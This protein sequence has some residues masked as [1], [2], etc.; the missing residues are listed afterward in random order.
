MDAIERIR[1]DVPA[2][3]GYDTG[4]ER[5]LSDERLRAFVGE[6][7]AAMPPD[8][9][10]GGLLQRCEFLNQRAFRLFDADPSPER[11][12]NV[13]E[14]DAA[15]LESLKGGDLAGVERAFE[16]RDAAMQQG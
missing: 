12:A 5:R 9:V 14:A 3:A 2:F 8:K 1:A 7:L 15:L 13:L 11:I 10:D 6:S 4:A 16:R